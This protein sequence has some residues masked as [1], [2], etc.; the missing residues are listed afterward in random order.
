ML[1]RNCCAAV[2][3][4]HKP[5]FFA[6]ERLCCLSSKP[7]VTSDL[8]SSVRDASGVGVTSY[9]PHCTTHLTVAPVERH[10]VRDDVTVVMTTAHHQQVPG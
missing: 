9:C 5:A 10:G 4:R 7:E 6:N 8:S 1:R 2:E 3:F